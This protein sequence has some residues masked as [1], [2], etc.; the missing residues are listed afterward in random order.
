LVFLSIKVSLLG[1]YEKQFEIKDF[2]T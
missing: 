2:D 1:D